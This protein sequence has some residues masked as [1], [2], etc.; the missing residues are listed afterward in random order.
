MDFKDIL[1]KVSGAYITTFFCVKK[2]DTNTKNKVKI[3]T[4]YEIMLEK[5]RSK[6]IG[7]IYHKFNNMDLVEDI[8]VYNEQK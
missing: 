5:R 2:L 3:K 1:N 4:F 8:F 6:A 7:F